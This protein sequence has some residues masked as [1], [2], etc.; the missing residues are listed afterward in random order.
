MPATTPTGAL[1]DKLLVKGY[2]IRVYPPTAASKRHLIVYWDSLKKRHTLSG[3]PTWESTEA[4]LDHIIHELDTGAHKSK[5]PVG[6]LVEAWLD[7]DRP[8]AKPWSLKHTETM[9]W[10]M[11]KRVLPTIG[12]LACADVTRSHVQAVVNTGVS[13]SDGSRIKRA[14]SAML[15][16]GWVHDWLT[17]DPKRLLGDVYWQGETNP[18]DGVVGL[19]LAPGSGDIPS[20]TAVHNLYT[21]FGKLPQARWWE[22]LPVLVAAYSGVRM[23][24]MLELRASD[25]DLATGCISVT[26]QAVEVRGHMVVTLPK[27]RK[28]RTTIYPDTTPQGVALA[29]LLKKRVVEVRKTNPDGLMFPAPKG[30]VWGATNFRNR[31]FKPAGMAAGW[32]ESPQPR[33]T[34]VWRWH[35]LRH[36]FATYLLWEKGV[37]VSDVAVAAGHSDVTTTLRVYGSRTSSALQSIRELLKNK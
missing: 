34:F 19:E 9:R 1:K 4:K 21:E 8:R 6:G 20:H 26:R 36:V 27:G 25:F 10:L 2:P 17:T 23:G 30:N 18:D 13:K 14:M 24:E 33:E 5:L 12:V 3:G 11:E 29:K 16:W 15:S 32:K 22:G 28:V 37:P 7:P 31:R 35:D